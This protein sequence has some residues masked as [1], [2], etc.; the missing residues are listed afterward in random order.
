[1]PLATPT[2][3]FYRRT[4]ITLLSLLP[5]FLHTSGLSKRPFVET[6][7]QLILHISG[8]IQLQCR[9]SCGTTLSKII[10]TRPNNK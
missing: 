1:M 3:R 4:L 2:T 6:L 5:L 7:Q 10:N 8:R 9:P